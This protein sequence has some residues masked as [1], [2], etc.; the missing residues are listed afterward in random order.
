MVVPVNRPVKVIMASEKVAPQGTDPT[1]RA[2][3]HSFFVPAFRVKQ[4]IVPG[5]YTTLW[6]EAEN[7]GDYW[8]FCA[9]YC[10]AG[11]SAMSG[12]I[13][14]V[15][16]EEFEQWLS[17]E[18]TAIGGSL[19]DQGRALYATKACIGC[20]SV[21]GSRVVGPSFKGLF[22]KTEQTNSGAVDVDEDY[23]R[24]SILNPNVSVVTGF[25]GGLMPP[26]AGQL[27]DD[28]VAALVEFIKSVK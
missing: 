22:G 21:D 27:T 12:R 9:E 14:V 23:L 10:G 1:D 8:L 26:Y 25:Q 7:V 11:H 4:D 17:S 16:T 6:F 28:E 24:E 5:R 13:K 2:V 3:L 15:T 19:A 18:G 20:H